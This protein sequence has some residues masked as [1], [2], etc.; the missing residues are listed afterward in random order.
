MLAQQVGHA[1]MYFKGLGLAWLLG[2]GP[3]SHLH[4]NCPCWEY[5]SGPSLRPTSHGLGDSVGNGQA[6]C[7]VTL[8]VE[9]VARAAHVG[10][11]WL[12]SGGYSKLAPWWVVFGAVLPAA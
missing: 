8:C 12:V 2:T 9:C 6:A 5:G 4:P 11:C 3:G 7:V 1:L 10:R